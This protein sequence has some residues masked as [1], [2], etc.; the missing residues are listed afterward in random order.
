M[1]NFSLSFSMCYLNA[2]AESLV[3][4]HNVS[5]LAVKCCIFRL[6]SFSFLVFKFSFD[7]VTVEKVVPSLRN[8]ISQHGS[9]QTN[10][11]MV[12]SMS[13]KINLL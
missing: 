3:T 13:I 1:K 9:R 12:S 8:F 2:D 7:I 10:E 4:S 5:L 11:G 6:F